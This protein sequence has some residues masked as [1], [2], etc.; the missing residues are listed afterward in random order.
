MNKPLLVVLTPVYNE[1]WILPAFL[2]AT[3]L[4]ADYILIAD[5]MSDDGSREIYKDF[6]KVRVIDNP[7][8]SMHQARTR[9]LLMDAS[10]EIEGDKILFTLDADE[11]LSGDFMNTS[12]WKYMLFESKPSDVFEFRWMNLHKNP[13][14]YSTWQ[15]YYW[16]VRYEEDVFN[17]NFPD[18]FIHESRLPWPPKADEHYINIFE[19][20]RFIHFARVNVTRQINKERY[21]QIVQKM[22]DPKRSNISFYRQYHPTITESTYVVPSDAYVFYEKN[23]LNLFDYIN[24]NDNGKHYTKKVM[25]AFNQNG[26]KM[27]S[28]LDV[29]D[30]AFLKE[31]NIKDPRS[32]IDKLMRLYLRSTS[33]FADNI[34][35]KFIDKILKLIY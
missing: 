33:R 26:L 10:K 16:A 18:N 25:D 34:I 5:Q 11:F 1:A 3:S 27:Y 24:L 2:R 14:V 15:P 29:W 17:G 35:I 9:R 19:D 32:W 21:Y 31:V 13:N 30:S 6:P 28:G 8:K 20:I 12:S 23:N 4:W 22:S 7:I